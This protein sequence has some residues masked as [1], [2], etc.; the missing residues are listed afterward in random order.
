MWEGS[1]KVSPIVISAIPEMQTIS[2][3]PASSTSTFFNPCY[4]S[5]RV[6]LCK[7]VCP[8]TSTLLIVCPLVTFPSRIRPQA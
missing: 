5:I 2:P 4:P 6:T 8:F 7:E 3:T 1:H